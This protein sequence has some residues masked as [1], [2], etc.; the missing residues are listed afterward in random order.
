M[1]CDTLSETGCWQ[2]NARS[3]A[4]S[5]LGWGL[6]NAFPVKA[7]ITREAGQV[8]IKPNKVSYGKEADDRELLTWETSATQPSDDIS[9]SQKVRGS[10]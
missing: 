2:V 1:H 8:E 5:G 6:E 9:Y 10:G 3:A 4:C 7:F